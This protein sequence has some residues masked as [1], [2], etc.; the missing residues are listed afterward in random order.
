MPAFRWEPPSEGRVP[1]FGTTLR[2]RRADMYCREFRKK[3]LAF[4]DDTL[5]GVDIATMREHLVACSACA[6]LDSD[7]R[8]ALLLVRNLPS[9]DISAGFTARLTDRIGRERR[10]PPFAVTGLHGPGMGMFSVLAAIV[11]VVGVASTAIMDGM[12]GAATI[13]QLPAV[14]AMPP[15]QLD[16]TT[17]PAMVASMSTGMLAWPALWLAERAPMHFA[18]AGVRAVSYQREQ[19]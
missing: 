10:R 13:P 14:V 18:K 2:T 6:R 1:R 9:V 19:R 4:I 12:R 8:R 16:S 3:H 5:P 7:I 11:V 15:V 17:A